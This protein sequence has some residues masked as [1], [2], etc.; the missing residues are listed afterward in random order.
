MVRLEANHT[1]PFK[2]CRLKEACV[3]VALV[4]GCQAHT[5][6]LSIFVPSN[7]R[8]PPIV[9][10]DVVVGVPCCDVDLEVVMQ[11]VVVGEVELSE[12]G[13]SYIELDT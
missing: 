4:K 9:H 6:K 13:L 7:C 2:H 11:G 1:L 5:S 8:D 12:G 10:Y 3:L